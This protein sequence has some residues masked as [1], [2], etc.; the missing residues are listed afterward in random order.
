VFQLIAYAPDGVLRFPV[1]RGSTLIGSQDGCDICLPYTGVAQEH[2]RVSYDGEEL[3][4]EDLG[5]RR[6]VL[7]RGRR[8]RDASLETLDEIRLG[9]VTLLVEELAERSRT[10]KAGTVRDPA[11]AEPARGPRGP[12]T[13]EI[14]LEHLSNISDWVLADVESRT[15]L[16]SLVGQLLHD[17]G[18]G[19]LFL[20]HGELAEEPGIKFVSVTDSAW[21]GAGEE[22]L[23]QVHARLDAELAAEQDDGEPVVAAEREGTFAGTLGGAASWIGFHTFRAV[24]RSY[25]LLVALPRFEEEDWSPALS[26]RSLGHLLVLG[27]VHH[28]GWY[29]P[30]LPGRKAQKELTLDPALV[31]GES[32]AMKAVLEQLRLAVEG[33][34]HLLL[35]GEPGSGLPLI[36][37]SLHL[38]SARREGPFITASCSGAQPGA[39]EIDLF[40]AEVAGKEG[41]VRRHGKLALAD[42]GT[43]LLEGVDELPETLQGRLLRFLGSGEIEPVGTGQRLA[44]DVRLVA[45]AKEPLEPLVG[46]DLFRVDLAYQLSRFSIDVP[47][48]RERREDL[49]LLIQS[50]VNRF[51]HETGK[52]MRGITVK[53]MSALLAY[54]FPGNLEE[55]ENIARQ[56]VYLCPAGQPLDLSLLP[57]KVRLST[58]QSAARV[59]ST[60]DLDLDRLVGATER[61]AIREALR[62]C[63]GNKSQAARLL[64][65]SRNGLA[66]KMQRRGLT[67]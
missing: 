67:A 23:V 18:G 39:I 20:L 59:D 40:G 61:A 47:P 26:L 14:M 1:G 50:Y 60:S 32:E 57:E 52:R 27:L 13:P 65:L 36:A 2:A 6:G 9:T 8:V 53:A 42:G 37:R 51:C 21:L 44:V 25:Q 46:R 19:A 30:I 3:R 12:L 7:V 49:P 16:E 55:L 38:S 41:P 58:I 33:D 31:V 64:G 43:L 28:V 34:I 63:H 45:A 15:P 48:L 22:L 62:R 4:I 5:S 11:V 56:L 24:E 10:G 17:C 29:E 35:R 54:D 66:L